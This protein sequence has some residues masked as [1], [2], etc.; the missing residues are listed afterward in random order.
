MYCSLPNE[1]NC[2]L[3]ITKGAFNVEGKDA[4]TFVPSKTTHESFYSAT[5][6]CVHWTFNLTI[7][8]S[9]FWQIN[10]GHLPSCLAHKKTRHFFRLWGSQFWS[11]QKKAWPSHL[12]QTSCI[13]HSQ[14]KK[15]IFSQLCFF[16]IFG[17][18]D[19]SES[20]LEHRC[21]LGWSKNQKEKSITEEVLSVDRGQAFSFNFFAG[22]MRFPP[23]FWL[24]EFCRVMISTKERSIILDQVDPNACIFFSHF[25]FVWPTV[26]ILYS[27]SFHPSYALLLVQSSDIAPLHSLRESTQISSLGDHP[28]LSEAVDWK[29]TQILS[30]WP[31]C[32]PLQLSLERVDA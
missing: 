15:Q 12:K 26:A 16:F 4:C 11:W 1:G 32:M 28:D 5:L 31:L 23:T 29:I 14:E 9:P 6:F 10:S 3:H 8:I 19:W 20:K 22:V 13:L 18:N 25:R 27:T 2:V 17:V 30:L 21:C 24:F 7:M